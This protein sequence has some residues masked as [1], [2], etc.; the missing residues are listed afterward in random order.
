MV[1]CSMSESPKARVA[2]NMQ[3]YIESRLIDMP[4]CRAAYLMRIP[5]ISD[6]LVVYVV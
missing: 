4:P 5:T 6:S 3:V 1:P 2:T